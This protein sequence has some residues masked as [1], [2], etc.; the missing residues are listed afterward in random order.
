MVTNT[1]TFNTS[2]KN[3]N[4]KQTKT[5]QHT[6]SAKRERESRTVNAKTGTGSMS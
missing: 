5:V 3:T 6:N 2:N 4:T 1:A